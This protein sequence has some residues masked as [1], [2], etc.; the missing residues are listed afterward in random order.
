MENISDA[1]KAMA[2]KHF[3][4]YKIRNGELIPRGS[5]LPAWITELAEYLRG[6]RP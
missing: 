6:K 5:T 1:V 4:S 2:T 3:G